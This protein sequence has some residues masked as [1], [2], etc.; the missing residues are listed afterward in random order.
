[1]LKTPQDVLSR[2]KAGLSLSQSDLYQFNLSGLD[3]QSATFNRATLLR[4]NL[5]RANLSQADLQAA[6]LRGADLH[7]AILQQANL[8]G[9]CLYRADLGGADLSGANLTGTQLQWARY[10]SQ[11][12]FPEGF[13]YKSS[14]VIGP[15]ANLNGARLVQADLRTA[16]LTGVFLRSARLN[17]ANLAGADLRAADLTGVEFE[18]F[19]SIAGADFPLVQGLSDGMR[20]R[21]LSHPA[22]QLETMHPLTLITTR[23]SLSPSS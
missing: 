4:A 12:I 3:L 11:T 13:A 5:S 18:Q 10:D 6:D 21:L 14:G 19:E 20:A 1:M 16:M 9:A 17:G 2:L 8:A 22:E 15:G 7:Q 23:E